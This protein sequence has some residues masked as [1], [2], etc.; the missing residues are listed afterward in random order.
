MDILQ[1]QEIAKVMCE[2]H[3]L[4]EAI[5]LFRRATNCDLMFSKT[6]LE[7]H[8]KDGYVNLVDKLCDDFV[9]SKEDI[10]RYLLEQR[11]Q[12]DL[13]IDVVQAEIENEARGKRALESFT[14]KQNHTT[15][16]P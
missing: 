12:L 6:Y 9:Q 11:R 1:A 3:R 15:Q 13:Q 16:T 14:Q 5:K 8:G 2:D 7:E 10:L 4:I